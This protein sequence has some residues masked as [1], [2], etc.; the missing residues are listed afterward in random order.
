MAL[1]FSR[2]LTVFL[3][4]PVPATHGLVAPPEKYYDL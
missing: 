3:A 1:R 4:L 2:G